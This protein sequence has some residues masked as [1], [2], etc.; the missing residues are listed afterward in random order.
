M[1][2][3]TFGAFSRCFIDWFD[4]DHFIPRQRFEILKVNHLSRIR[5]TQRLTFTKTKHNKNALRQNK[6]FQK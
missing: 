3:E 6:T 1:I 5:E 2:T 4:E